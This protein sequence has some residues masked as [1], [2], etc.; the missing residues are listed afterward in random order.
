[1]KT[2]HAPIYKIMD[3]L[4]CMSA[5]DIYIHIIITYYQIN[6]SHYCAGIIRILFPSF[7]S[8]MTSR[9]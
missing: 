9:C 6:I 8:P 7:L 5:Q 3:M 4:M 2:S 1:M